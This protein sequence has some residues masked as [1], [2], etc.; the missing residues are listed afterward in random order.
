MTLRDTEMANCKELKFLIYPCSGTASGFS[1]KKS[2]TWR[3]TSGKFSSEKLVVPTCSLLK[4]ISFSVRVLKHRRK[5]T[6]DY[7]LYRH[8]KLFLM[9]LNLERF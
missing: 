1:P 7:E 8:L 2:A 5:Q 3:L 4:I 9:F 6:E